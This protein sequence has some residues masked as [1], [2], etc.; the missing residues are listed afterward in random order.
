[1]LN[2]VTTVTAIIIRLAWF[3]AQPTYYCKCPHSFCPV[4]LLVH[5][6]VDIVAT[7][8]AIIICLA[9]FIT[10]PAYYCK[11]PHSFCPVWSL[12]H[13]PVAIVVLSSML[14]PV[15]EPITTVHCHLHLIRTHASIQGLSIHSHAYAMM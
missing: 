5:C 4:W 2:P 15:V 7:I 1:M 14:S 8:T 12:V 9:Q 3:I 6:P 10:Q 11:C 13:C